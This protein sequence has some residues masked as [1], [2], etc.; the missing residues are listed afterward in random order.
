MLTSHSNKTTALNKQIY[1]K[2]W[3]IFLIQTSCFIA[4]A[5]GQL[6]PRMHNLFGQKNQ[7][8]TFLGFHGHID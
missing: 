3:Y 8:R 7:T 2:T 4:L 6:T 1:I 5:K